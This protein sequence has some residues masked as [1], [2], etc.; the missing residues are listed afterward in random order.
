MDLSSILTEVA[1]AGSSLCTKCRPENRK[2]AVDC[3]FPSS[4]NRKGA[5]MQC[6][7]KMCKAEAKY[8]RSGSLHLID[9][10][11]SNALNV[12]TE[13]RRV[14]WLCAE[15][16]QYLTVESWRPPGQQLRSHSQIGMAN[17]CSTAA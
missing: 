8:L 10:L 11:E 16:S 14:V 9:C 12:Q 17:D 2:I 7:N 5:Y 6:F 3:F 4:G 1:D 15:C 13:R